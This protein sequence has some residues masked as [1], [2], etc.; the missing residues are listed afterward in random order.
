MIILLH[1]EKTRLKIIQLEKVRFVKVNELKLTEVE[2]FQLFH[3]MCAAA[4]AFEY[5]SMDHL[6][7]IEP[8]SYHSNLSF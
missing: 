1:S 3:F 4:N 2:L 7:N 6:A 5:F 8:S